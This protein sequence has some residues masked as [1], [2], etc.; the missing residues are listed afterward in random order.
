MR[1]HARE[2]DEAPLVGG[3][4]LAPDGAHGREV[5]VGDGAAVLERRAEGSELRL[6][7]ADADAEGQPAAR[8]HVETRQLLGEHE[9]VA[10]RA[11]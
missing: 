9:R 4:R 3:L 10:L 2:G 1:L 7:I 8:Q 5:F 11:G 6:E